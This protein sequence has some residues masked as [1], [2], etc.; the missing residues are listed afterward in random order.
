MPSTSAD[1]AP[2]GA[3]PGGVVSV[4][5]G[6]AAGAASPAATLGAATVDWLGSVGVGCLLYTSDAADD[7]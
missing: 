4:G 5:A 1:S 2:A 6:A 3:R 7:M